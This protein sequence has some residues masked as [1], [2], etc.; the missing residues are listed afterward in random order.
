MS[1]L[2]VP[3]VRFP[4]R[5][6]LHALCQDPQRPQPRLVEVDKTPVPRL[7]GVECLA[8]WPIPTPN[9]G[10]EPNFH[11]YM[12]EEHTP[13]NLPDSHR[14]FQGRDDATIISATEAPEVPCS[15][16]SS[17]SKQT[18][19]WVGW[20]SC[21]HSGNWCQCGWRICC[22]TYFQFAVKREER[23]RSKR[24][25]IRW[26]T[27]KIHRKIL[28]QKVDSA[29]RGERKAQQKLYEVEARN[30]EKRNSDI[31]FHEIN[32]EF[33][34]QRFQCQ[35]IEEL[36][37]I[38]CEET[39]RARRA[40]IDELS[41]H[42]DGESYDRESIN[43]SDIGNYRTE[44]ILCQTPEIFYDLELGSSSGATPVPDQT[45]SC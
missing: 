37:R 35:E 10:Y 29:I 39:D 41:V 12:N 43:D 13:I 31:A 28:E 45:L 32:Q 1:L 20:Q 9:T 4:P 6:H 30:W 19:A 26:E 11:S 27:E 18:A 42:Q 5:P 34:S 21:E 36:K 8:P 24:R 44:K 38:C 40:R 33:E 2:N 23:S 16:A 3:F 25:G 7:T 22:S 17:S 15:G 14:C